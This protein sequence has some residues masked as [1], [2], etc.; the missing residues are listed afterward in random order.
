[1][2]WG[3]LGTALAVVLNALLIS[4]FAHYLAVRAIHAR[5]LDLVSLALLPAFSTTIMYI[6]LSLSRKWLLPNQCSTSFIA[7]VLVG[8]VVYLTIIIIFDKKSVQE[9][10]QFFK[11]R[12]EIR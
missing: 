2:R 3:I 8:S 7:F 4:P 11:M 10:Y 9:I 12:L 6:C 5:G 1:M